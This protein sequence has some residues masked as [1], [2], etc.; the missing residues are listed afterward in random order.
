M[1]QDI[2]AYLDQCSHSPQK[3]RLVIDLV[4][5]KPAVEAMNMLRK[6]GRASCRERV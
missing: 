3:V 2:R 1:A 6:I 4:R 5:G